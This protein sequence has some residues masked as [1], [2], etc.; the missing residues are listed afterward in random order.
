MLNIKSLSIFSSFFAL[1][2]TA[3][4]ASENHE[5]FD[6][7]PTFSSQQ[8]MKIMDSAY[9]DPDNSEES[10]RF[11]I[12]QAKKRIR[13]YRDQ[14]AN[15]LFNH[16]L[17]ERFSHQLDTSDMVEYINLLNNIAN[18]KEE[19][20]RALKATIEG[21]SQIYRKNIEDPDYVDCLMKSIDVYSGYSLPISSVYTEAF[22]L[23]CNKIYYDLI[24]ANTQNIE[25]FKHLISITE[26]I[27][28]RFPEHIT[29][30]IVI[31]TAVSYKAL[32]KSEEAE[33]IIKLGKQYFINLA[34]K[35]GKQKLH[36]EITLRQVTITTQYD[37]IPKSL[38]R[39]LLKT[40]K[41]EAQLK[42]Q[43][44]MN[45]ISEEYKVFLENLRNL[46]ITELVSKYF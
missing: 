25:N 44:E 21:F 6:S 15:I 10:K 2:Y 27:K 20:S 45:S 40:L 29:S 41:E 46:D 5:R 7:I 33:K 42:V 26:S 35:N 11:N 8:I 1:F 22:Y 32:G 36:Q 30:Q 13:N 14:D 16:I 18:E 28:N 3:T 17:Y 24:N 23:C 9:N 4:Q 12:E 39:E 38:T 19:W 37:S 43:Q 34:H 31:N